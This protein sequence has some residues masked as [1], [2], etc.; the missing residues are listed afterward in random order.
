M[1]TRFYVRAKWDAEA[2]VFISDTNIPG[3]NVEA[4]TLAGFVS[5][6]EEL[7]PMMLEANVAPEDR[8]RGAG[9][10]SPLMNRLELEIAA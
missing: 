7:A 4:E 10:G 1:T 6:V 9:D 5:A 2:G 8:P 3:L